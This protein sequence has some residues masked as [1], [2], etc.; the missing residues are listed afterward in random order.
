MNESGKKFVYEEVVKMF[1]LRL[2]MLATLI[3][4]E[5]I[6]VLPLSARDMSTKD[7]LTE[8]DNRLQNKMAIQDAIEAGRERAVLCQS[9][10]GED[11]NS[12]KPEVP[13]LAG[14]NAGY[15]LEQINRF[16]DGRRVD[17]VMNQLAENF[18]AEDKINIAVFYYSMSVKPQHVNW[19]LAS[20]GETL[21]KDRCSGCHGDEGFGHEKLARLAGQQVEYVKS[22]LS[23]FRNTANKVSSLSESQRTSPSMERVAKNLTDEQIEELA[24]FVAQLGFEDSD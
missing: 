17:F 2:V 4:M 16:A 9:C 5:F 1:S 8:I 14:Q 11:G 18:S 19:H 20:K 15:L 22:T 12:A 23:K 6:F 7:M 13:N 10:H 21:Y 24:H 3:V